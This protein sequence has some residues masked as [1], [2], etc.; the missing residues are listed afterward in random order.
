M[1][2]V[3]VFDAHGQPQD[4]AW[5]HSRYGNI[6]IDEAPEGVKAFRIYRLQ[7]REDGD[8]SIKVNVRD[9]D[10]NPSQHNVA[11]H[12]AGAPHQDKGCK[13]QPDN[14]FIHQMSNGNGDTAFAMGHG[15]YYWPPQA[16]TH[17]LWACSGLPSDVINGMGMLSGTNHFHVDVW[18][19]ISEGSHPATDPALPP[20]VNPPIPLPVTPTPET[21]GQMARQIQ[22]IHDHFKP[23]T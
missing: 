8:S 3:Q 14:R 6:T 12:W 1:P 5:L 21:G 15:S 10:G 4:M 23:C 7:A 9:A 11:F 22:E 13:T 16:G 19:H 18:F 20:I 17:K 2:D